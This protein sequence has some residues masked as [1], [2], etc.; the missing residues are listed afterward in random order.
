MLPN[1]WLGATS[2]V[3]LNLSANKVRVRPARISFSVPLRCWLCEQQQAAPRQGDVATHVCVCVWIY[4]CLG[5]SAG[6]EPNYRAYQMSRSTKASEPKAHV[7]V[8]AALRPAQL[9]SLPPSLGELPNLQL[10]QANSNALPALPA[11]L[12]RLAGSLT[13]LKLAR[14]AL[15]QL[16]GGSLGVMAIASLQVLT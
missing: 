9:R 10:L 15:E 3:R 2:L 16:D 6:A 7:C 5:T 14:N 4:I 1:D 12:A 11:S 8:C 13:T